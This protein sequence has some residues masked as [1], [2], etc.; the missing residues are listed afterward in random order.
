MCSYLGR[1]VGDFWTII[2]LGLGKLS[3][4]SDIYKDKNIAKRETSA[5]INMLFYKI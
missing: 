1:L 3:A 2:V 4:L 5:T